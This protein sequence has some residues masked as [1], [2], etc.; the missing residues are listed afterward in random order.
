M[1][2]AGVQSVTIPEGDVKSIAIGGVT[3]WEKSNPLP[4]DAEVEFLECVDAQYIDTGIYPT[5]TTTFEIDA[6]A[7]TIGKSANQI[8]F[9]SRLA[10]ESENF[11]V[12][13]FA[14][15][16]NKTR[17]AYGDGPSQDK[18]P[19]VADG[20]RRTFSSTA[21][22]QVLSI[23]VGYSI[24]SPYT[25]NFNSHYPIYLFTGNFGTNAPNSQYAV[26]AKIYSAKFYNGSTLVRSFIPVRVGQTGYLFDRVSGQLFGNAGTGSFVLGSDKNGG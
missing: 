20:T 7:S 3:V 17:W 11:Y 22:K 13:F 9:G 1:N 23:S 10:G 24:I 18:T 12:L 19:F 26:G 16:G 15:A 6:S 14:S 25:S 8:L 2:F 4:Y 21:N 5:S